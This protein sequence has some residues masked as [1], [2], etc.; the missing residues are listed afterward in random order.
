MDGGWQTKVEEGEESGDDKKSDQDAE[1]SS[2]PDQKIV[3]DSLN[4]I[5]VSYK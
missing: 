1:D 3:R 4:E 5:N 2:H